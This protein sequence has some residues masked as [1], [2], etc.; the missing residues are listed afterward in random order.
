VIHEA[1]NAVL[2]E[3]RPRKRFAGYAI[4]RRKRTTKSMPEFSPLTLAEVWLV[5]GTLG[6]CQLVLQLRIKGRERY[7]EGFVKTL[8]YLTGIPA[9]SALA[10]FLIDPDE[11]SFAFIRLSH[12][13][14][15]AGRVLFGGAALVILW[16]HITLGRFWSGELETLPEHRLI[17]S[18]PYAFVRHP[19]YSSYLVLTVGFFLATADWFV[20]A[21]MLTY[22]VAVTTRANKEEE[23]LTGRLGPVYTAYCER[24]P[25]FLPFPP[26]R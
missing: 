7:P 12:D 22:F 20:G 21:L 8:Q 6:C 15:I 14:S 24:T 4:Q 5:L 17:R 19:L 23:M 10:L 2:C 18:G 26:R 13:V 16:C 25:R 3:S 9:L 1:S 11:L